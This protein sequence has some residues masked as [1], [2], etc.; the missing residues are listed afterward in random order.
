MK[1]QMLLRVRFQRFYTHYKDKS[2]DF[3]LKIIKVTEDKARCILNKECCR[4]PRFKPRHL[5]L[6]KIRNGKYRKQIFICVWFFSFQNRVW[7]WSPDGLELM[8]L[9]QL[10]AH[11]TT[12]ASRVL[13]NLA[14][15][16]ILERWSHCYVKNWLEEWILNFSMNYDCQG[17]LLKHR[18]HTKEVAWW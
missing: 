8:I 15:P 18:F 17:W 5:K 13:D 6:L 14:R 7:F 10:W 11:D 4:R 2:L 16:L 3:K 12:S 1:N 9:L